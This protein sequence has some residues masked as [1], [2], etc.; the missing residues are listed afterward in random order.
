MTPTRV[1][2]VKRALSRYAPGLFQIIRSSRRSLHARNALRLQASLTQWKARF[3]AD[4]QFVVQSGPFAG[5]KWHPSRPEEAYLPLLVGSY[6]QEIHG[7]LETALSRAPALIVDVGCEAGFVAVGLALRALKAK[8]I[9]FDIDP[10]ARDKC[11]ALVER[12]QVGDRVV[13]EE[14]CTP[15]AL[16]QLCETP[17][18]LVFCDCEGFEYELL[19]PS[20]A[21]RLKTA[22]IIVEL[23]DFM[24]LDVDITPTLVSRFS[25]THEIAIHGVSGRDPARYPCLDTMPEAVRRRAIREDR[26]S[27]QQWAYLK[28]K[29]YPPAP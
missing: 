19:D 4:H 13:V 7:F 1:Q 11:R 26:V 18:V 23:H 8:V 21:P 24:R 14:A 10:Q 27:Y 9:G 12:N 20:L 2:N 6:E 16:D 5:L 3:I 15:A 22:D 17:R 29:A 25:A 28:A